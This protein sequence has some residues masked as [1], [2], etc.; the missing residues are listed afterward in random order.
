MLARVNRL[1]LKFKKASPDNYSPECKDLCAIFSRS[2]DQLGADRDRLDELEKQSSGLTE[3]RL[4]PTPDSVCNC[5]DVSGCGKHHSLPKYQKWLAQMLLTGHAEQISDYL[6]SALQHLTFSES[7]YKKLLL[8]NPKLAAFKEPLV[9]INQ[10]RRFQLSGKVMFR[11]GHTLLKNAVLIKTGL[12]FR[13]PRLS[14]LN[15]PEHFTAS[16]KAFDE[17]SAVDEALRLTQKYLKRVS[18][19]AAYISELTK[20]LSEWAR[21][22]QLAWN[23]DEVLDFPSSEP[24]TY[25]SVSIVKEILQEAAHYGL[26]ENVREYESLSKSIEAVLKMDASDATCTLERETRYV[27][28]CCTLIALPKRWNSCHCQR[29]GTVNN[30]EPTSADAL[31]V[32]LRY[33]SYASK[34]LV[35]RHSLNRVRTS[36]RRFEEASK[37]QDAAAASNRVETE[38]IPLLVDILRLLQARICLTP[39]PTSQQFKIQQ[40]LPD[41]ISTLRSHG[42]VGLLRRMDLT[43]SANK[44]TQAILNEFTKIDDAEHFKYFLEVVCGENGVP[45]GYQQMEFDVDFGLQQEPGFLMVALKLACLVLRINAIHQSWVNKPI[46]GGL[47]RLFV[48][49]NLYDRKNLAVLERSRDTTKAALTRYFEKFEAQL[50]FDANA[51]LKGNVAE[52]NGVHVTAQQTHIRTQRE[53]AALTQHWSEAEYGFAE[54]LNAELSQLQTS[55]VTQISQ[56]KS[57]VTGVMKCATQIESNLRHHPWRGLEELRLYVDLISEKATEIESLWCGLLGKSLLEADMKS[58]LVHFLQMNQEMIMETSGETVMTLIID[59]IFDEAR[60]HQHDPLQKSAFQV[61]GCFIQHIFQFFIAAHQVLQQKKV[62]LEF[63]RKR[64]L[65]CEEILRSKAAKSKPSKVNKPPTLD[66]GKRPSCGDWMEILVPQNH[67]YRESSNQRKLLLQMLDDFCCRILG[68]D[69][70]NN[71]RRAL[72]WHLP[73]LPHRLYFRVNDTE[74]VLP[75]LVHRQRVQKILS[76]PDVSVLILKAGTGSGKSTQLPQYILDLHVCDDHLPNIWVSQPRRLA[77]KGVADRVRAEFGCNTCF[78]EIGY[79]LG[80]KGCSEAEVARCFSDDNCQVLQMTTKLLVFRLQAALKGGELADYIIIDEAH[81]RTLD[82]DTC[83][84]LL[85]ELLSLGK[86]KFKVIITSATIDV[87]KFHQYFSAPSLLQPEANE[88][89]SQGRTKNSIEVYEVPSMTYPV[90]YEYVFCSREDTLTDPDEMIGKI[91]EQ[92]IRLHSKKAKDD[93]EFLVFLPTKAMIQTA[94]DLLNKSQEG[95]IQ[96]IL[97]LALFRGNVDNEKNLRKDFKKPK[98]HR[99]VFFATNIA[100]TSL[101]FNNV[102]VVLDSGWECRQIFDKK[103]GI[104]QF[105]S[106]NPVSKASAD[107]RKGRAGRTGPG[108]CLR[109]YSEEEYNGFRDAA[110]PEIT[111]TPLE[112]IILFLA[113]QVTLSFNDDRQGNAKLFDWFGFLEKAFLTDGPQKDEIDF[114]FM[115]LVEL[116]FVDKRCGTWRL[117]PDGKKAEQL[118]PY[119]SPWDTRCLLQA[120]ELGCLEEMAIV[121]A[122]SQSYRDLQSEEAFKNILNPGGDV[123]AVLDKYLND[124]SLF[125]KQIQQL[126]WDI[127]KAFSRVTGKGL[128]NIRKTNRPVHYQELVGKCL[129]SGYFHRLAVPILKTHRMAGFYLPDAETI[130]ELHKDSSLFKTTDDFGSDWIISLNP[131]LQTQLRRGKNGDFRP[132]FPLALCLNHR[133]SPK[134]LM[135][136]SKAKPFLRRCMQPEPIWECNLVD[137]FGRRFWDQFKI[138]HADDLVFT[139][140]FLRYFFDAKSNKFFVIH[141]PD[142]L[143]NSR[144]VINCASAMQAELEL[145]RRQVRELRTDIECNRFVSLKEKSLVLDIAARKR[146]RFADVTIDE[147]IEL[148]CTRLEEED[149]GLG[150]VHV[151]HRDV[152]EDG[153][154]AKL[155][156]RTSE[157]CEPGVNRIKDYLG[158]LRETRK[159]IR[160]CMEVKSTWKI[161]RPTPWGRDEMKTKLDSL[162]AEKDKLEEDN[163]FFITQIDVLDD[164]RL[165]QELAMFLQEKSSDEWKEIFPNVT[166]EKRGGKGGKDVFIRGPRPERLGLILRLEMARRAY[167]IQMPNLFN[168]DRFVLEKELDGVVAQHR[169]RHCAGHFEIQKNLGRFVWQLRH[170]N[171]SHSGIRCT[172]LTKL[173]QKILRCVIRAEEKIVKTPSVDNSNNCQSCGCR[174]TNTELT[175]CGHR[176]CGNCLWA[177]D[178]SSQQAACP[179]KG[180]NRSICIC[181]TNIAKMA[182]IPEDL[183]TLMIP[184]VPRKEG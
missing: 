65:E 42:I 148:V 105:N 16:T 82:V 31:R 36:W 58:F 165:D 12:H 75:M 99:K 4:V 9:D 141:L 174:W 88:E 101:T 139:K 168:Q 136:T 111:E 73:K 35:A 120:A 3:R 15:Q 8:F 80:K 13:A 61:L 156:I 159:H 79:H 123:L 121:V 19:N 60:Q 132:E 54:T 115:R 162:H 51:D 102:T 44:D 145:R 28:L 84:I 83:L 154:R 147:A 107:Q 153:R 98:E 158:G 43:Q 108:E 160:E 48:D 172:S 26:M 118:L 69:I 94:I 167:S 180:C 7:V 134:W 135:S 50:D 52:V 46:V 67:N 1:F 77:A 45:L 182:R 20:Q 91:I 47:C 40:G 150:R 140:T 117:T 24:G 29:L 56:G 57:A 114:A 14:V 122:L 173:R 181:D 6:E 85:R 17:W 152:Q 128:S 2:V 110:P 27:E 109:F 96:G 32:V 49:S 41:V 76:S 5:E 74:K 64:I 93:D 163:L 11:D 127:I 70:D 137:N 131:Q 23:T 177:E 116:G 22:N 38:F 37:T 55:Y 106:K 81:E 124:R 126:V 133:V 62:R 18:L 92:V 89:F 97:P 149:L 169:H 176:L 87:E 25:G 138:T 130:G 112:S 161:S 183:K 30:L 142:R 68:S 155:K 78:E 95:Q 66:S 164:D 146:K 184:V 33:L 175:L 171:C 170:C 157:P 21:S 129:C 119:S 53:S 166:I 143:Y 113:E 10:L 178:S 34:V 90:D 144:D 39:L 86:H 59:S 63:L 103:L 72:E 71:T 104:S 125:P 151:F 100:E 179:V